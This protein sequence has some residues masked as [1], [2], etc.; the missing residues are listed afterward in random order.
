MLSELWSGLGRSWN[1]CCLKDN[2]WREI[3]PGTVL[4][5]S[6]VPEYGRKNLYGSTSV[7]CSGM[8]FLLEFDEGKPFFVWYGVPYKLVCILCCVKF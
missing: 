2:C 1:Q 3:Y 5:S 8:V 4:V 6:G 7:G